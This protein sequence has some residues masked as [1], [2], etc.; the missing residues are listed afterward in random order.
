[1]EFFSSLSHPHPQFRIIGQSSGDAESKYSSALTTNSTMYCRGICGRGN[2]Y[3]EAISVSVVKSGKYHF[4]SKSHID[5]YGYLYKHSFDP[6]N[7]RQNL[8]VE[9]NDSGKKRQFKFKIHL[10]SH[11]SYVLVVTT[12]LPNVTGSF[13]IIVSGSKS[14][15]FPRTSK[16][17]NCSSV[18]V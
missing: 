6:L 8:L 2:F 15:K 16:S 3:Y 10:A 7:P 1:M 4:S 14:V 5:T 9:S 13:S 18:F 11:T 12:S 17:S